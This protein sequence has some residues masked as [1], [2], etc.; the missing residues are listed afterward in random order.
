[1]KIEECAEEFKVEERLQAHRHSLT[2]E[3][4]CRQAQIA[5]LSARILAVGFCH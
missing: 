4:G 5:I 1:M 3:R 2:V